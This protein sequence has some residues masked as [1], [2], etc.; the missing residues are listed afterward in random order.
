MFASDVINQLQVM[1]PKFTDKFTDSVSISSI[2][3]S[4]LTATLTTATAHG[5]VIGNEANI[6]GSLSPINISSISRNENIATATTLQDHDLTEGFF[7]T[8]TLVGTE[9]GLFDGTFPFLTQVNRRTF[10]FE[11]TDTGATSGDFLLGGAALADVPLA[12][13]EGIAIFSGGQLS[14]PGAVGGYN[15]LF[16][17][18]SVPTTTSFTYLTEFA[19]PNAAIVNTGEVRNGIRIGGAVDHDR[20]D[21]AYTKSGK[22]KFWAFVIL[23]DVS[24][25]KD[26]HGQNDAI[27]SHGTSGSQRQQIIQPFMVEIFIPSHDDITGRQARD[28]AEALVPDIY[29]SLVGAKIPSGLSDSGNLGAYFVNS[30]TVAYNTSYYVY[31]MRFQLL[32]NIQEADSVDP[33][34][35]VA[36]RDISLTQ[37]NTFGDE[38]LTAT[39]DLDD[40]SL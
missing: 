13:E 24:A 32:T 5:L 19:Q 34:F 31:G 23:E 15:G 35:S 18:V 17:L 20:A 40:E 39:I 30:G 25:S 14:T 27:S 26:R 37:T 9:Q 11:V 6:A 29:H 28:A 16:T 1:L 3:S 22:D 8:V 2:T 38:P 7:T 10:T 4:G 12:G 21:A 33:E 36:F